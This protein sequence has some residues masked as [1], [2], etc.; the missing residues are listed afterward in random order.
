MSFADPLTSLVEAGRRVGDDAVAAASGAR[1]ATD[2]A[3][4]LYTSGTTANPKG[5][6]LTHDA[7]TRSWSAYADV[8]GLSAGE[9][10]WTPCPFFHVGGIGPTVAALTRGATMMSMTHF[11]PALALEH[12]E[13]RRAEHLFPAF[14]PLTLGLVRSPAYDRTRLSWLRTVLNVAPKDT[15]H[16]IQ[17]VLPD[18]AVLLTDFGMTEGAGMITL[19]TLDDSEEDRLGRNGRPM[20]GIEVRITDPELP[21]APLPADTPGEIQFRG[22]NAF[23]AYY[24]D[25]E[26]TADTIL[27]GGWVRTGDSGSVDANGSLVFLGR[28][29]DVLKVGGEN[30]SPLEVEAHLSTHP[31][32]RTVQVVGRPSSRYGEEP[33]AFVELAEG[34]DCTGEEIVAFCVGHLASY[35]VPREVRFVTSWPMSATKIQKF[36]LRE[37][38]RPAVS[39]GQPDA[40]R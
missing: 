36:R 9:S 24:Q 32:V 19:T 8:V 7:L 38:L 15:Q 29:K 12:I 33:V 27:P 39:E 17:A 35:K 28:T 21:H 31:A 5:C 30:V 1:G 37:L 16:M 34:V 13:R 20:P 14:P 3:V 10:V 40:A 11:E 25:P 2:V 26:A 4:L 18:G 23:R 6:E 22:I